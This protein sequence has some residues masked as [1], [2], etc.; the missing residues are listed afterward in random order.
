MYRN[1]Y[2][3]SRIN[4][5]R[6]ATAVAAALAFA[7][8][9]AAL[10]QTQ[11]GPGNGPPGGAHHWKGGGDGDMIGMTIVHAK[12]Q[13][14][15][16]TSQSQMFDAALA[17]S[18][19]A[20]QT[21]KGL[22]HQVHDALATELAKPEPDLSAVAAVA[23]SVH[24]QGAA[25]RKQVRASWLSLYATFSPDQKNVVKGIMQQH[26]ARMDAIQQKMQQQ[27]AATPSS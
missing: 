10:G 24:D 21:G 9:G 4:A 25:L 19:A 14:N 13:L 1:S 22:R 7:V 5:R 11:P 23:D 17:Q 6:A 3:G 12:S 18:K 8:A 20:R 15:L 26:L 16:N 27:H 2:H